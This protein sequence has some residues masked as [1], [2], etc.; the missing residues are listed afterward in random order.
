MRLGVAKN[1]VMFVAAFAAAFA[2]MAVNAPGAKSQVGF[3]QRMMV[4]HQ[5]PQLHFSILDTSKAPTA[6]AAIV[7]KFIGATTQNSQLVEGHAYPDHRDPSYLYGVSK[8]GT[9][10]RRIGQTGSEIE[11]IGFGQVFTRITGAWLIEP[12]PFANPQ[13]IPGGYDLKEHYAVVAEVNQGN[14]TLLGNSTALMLINP[15]TMAGY[16]VAGAG[17]FFGPSANIIFE[18]VCF[19]VYPG[20]DGDYGSLD[21]NEYRYAMAYMV[22]GSQDGG[23]YFLSLSKHETMNGVD[24]PDPFNP[25][26]QERGPGYTNVV[27]RMDA[28]TKTLSISGSLVMTNVVPNGQ[29]YCRAYYLR[30]GIPNCTATPE[31]TYVVGGWVTEYPG[32]PIT[33]RPR[34]GIFSLAATA[35]AVTL[36]TYNPPPAG[37]GAAFTAGPP[38]LTDDIFKSMTIVGDYLFAS[39]GDGVSGDGFADDIRAVY[40]PEMI[41]GA[42]DFDDGFRGSIQPHVGGSQGYTGYQV[43]FSGAPAITYVGSGLGVSVMK[44]T[45][46]DMF[47]DYGTHPMAVGGGMTSIDMHTDEEKL[48]GLNLRQAPQPFVGYW[49]SEDPAN[50][51]DG[52]R[53]GGGDG[54]GAGGCTGSAG[55]G[56]AGSI[57]LFSLVGLAF[58][59]VQLLR[60][61]HKA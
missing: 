61:T 37:P 6:S 34:L 17:M 36:I 18:D 40:L 59:M 38:W 3:Q 41:D 28:N 45:T 58:L 5:N 4:M 33:W 20:P 27:P 25:V 44:G 50:N 13:T 21:D 30:P 29:Q 46:V 49:F 7:G 47:Q 39:I 35:P 54:S 53:G 56:A 1:N 51:F 10:V 57:G 2:A 11:S 60:E 22:A 26:P 19:G 9:T 23:F 8:D 31:R 24:P 42:G 15:S 55:G 12:T 43:N 14:P 52:A 32:N 16:P 48:L